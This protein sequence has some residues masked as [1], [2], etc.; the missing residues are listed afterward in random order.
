[1]VCDLLERPLFDGRHLRLRPGPTD[2]VANFASGCLA[3]DDVA[4]FEVN[5]DINGTVISLSRNIDMHF[6]FNYSIV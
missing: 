2:P 1:M 6:L 3:T 5:K 4:K